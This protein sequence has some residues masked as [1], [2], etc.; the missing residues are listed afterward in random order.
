MAKFD[1]RPLLCLNLF[2]ENGIVDV[3]WKTIREPLRKK[4]IYPEN[5]WGVF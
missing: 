1:E 2:L 3:E 5:D 4:N